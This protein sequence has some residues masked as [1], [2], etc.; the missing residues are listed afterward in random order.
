MRRIVFWMALLSSSI[1]QAGDIGCE[2]T[3]AKPASLGDGALKF[4]YDESGSISG[5]EVSLPNAETLSLTGDAMPLADEVLVDFKSPGRLVLGNDLAGSGRISVSCSIPG[6]RLEYDGARLDT[7]TWTVM[8]PNASL[9]DYVPLKSVRGSG[10]GE[11]DTGVYYPYNV[12]RFEEDGFEQMSVTLV[13][14][15]NG[16]VESKI[17]LMRLRQNGENIEGIIDG[18]CYHATRYL[19]GEDI[20]KL[21]ERNA[22]SPDPKFT[23]DS[24][25]HT[26]KSAGG[27]GVDN[28]FMERADAPELEFR[29]KVA[30]AISIKPSIGVSVRMLPT[31]AV[32]G[33]ANGLEGSGT[34]TIAAPED[35]AQEP[36]VDVYD[37]FVASSPVTVSRN[38]MLAALTNVFADISGSYVRGEFFPAQFCQV[39]GNNLC[40]TGEVQVATDNYTWRFVVLELKQS[41][42]DIVAK[43]IDAGWIK[44][45]VMDIREYV[46]VSSVY[47]PQF[48]EWRNSCTP[49]GSPTG[50]PVG[51][52]HFRFVYSEAAAQNVEIGSAFVN[53]MAA[54]DGLSRKFGADAVLRIGGSADSRVGVRIANNTSASAFPQNGIVEVLEGGE[55]LMEYGIISEN[56]S[57]IRVMPGGRLRIRRATALDA[58][59]YVHL[60]GGELFV[61]DD[62][63]PSIADSWCYLERLSLRDGA[64]VKGAPFQMGYTSSSASWRVAGDFPSVCEASALLKGGSGSD[65]KN[66]EFNVLDVTDDGAIDFHYRGDINAHT[67][68]TRE[69]RLRKTGGGTL[70]HYGSFGNL[71]ATA[72]PV[73]I[74]AGEWLMHSS[75]SPDQPYSMNGG[76]LSAAAGTENSAGVLAVEKSGVLS[77]GPG[78]RISFADSS[79]AVWA[80]GARV[81]VEGDLASGAIRFGES[82]SALAPEQLAKMRYNGH[83]VSL[84]EGGYLRD[85][86]V[87]GMVITVK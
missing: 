54:E 42:L 73:S 7:D 12:K 76:N 20:E 30:S 16:F 86:G 51:A 3:L 2:W 87:P 46:A 43:A 25:V 36:L 35:G 60:Q 71:I 22:V 33:M 57:L 79:S 4:A 1:M 78:G 41:G 67:A 39:R 10:D 61:R 53:S 6:R 14:S 69:A 75:V 68:S 70:A 27:Y 62:A 17:I 15:R 56:S 26:P 59:Q 32:G 18:A 38:R 74:E 48:D 58:G 31:A 49:S 85:A 82:S 24:T 50:Q 80:D 66:M 81:T 84:D 5:I 40:I 21:I 44:N 37:E 72:L 55:L 11:Y 34:F 52:C 47:D 65:A 64:V 8:F 83:R 9:A 19:Q 63:L 29:G 28:F 23:A 45:G 13:Q 77:V